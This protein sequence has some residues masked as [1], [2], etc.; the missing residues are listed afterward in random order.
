MARRIR[1]RD[2]EY[3]GH[4]NHGQ[5]GLRTSRSATPIEDNGEFKAAELIDVSEFEEALLIDKN[6]LDEHLEQQADLF[7]RVSKALTLA[8]SRRDAAKQAI[9]EAEA[10]VELGLHREKEKYTVSE[11]KAHVTVNPR[12]RNARRMFA[13]LNRQVM[14]LAGLKEAFAQRSYAMKELV[15]LY[16]GSYWGDDDAKAAKRFRNANA[17]HIRREMSEM[18]RQ[19]S[20]D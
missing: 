5:D 19:R 4:G 7:N 13:D 10:E 2:S 18:R 17:D 11:I 20:R 15:S 14:D 16:L 8:T 3:D 9:A 12:V 6:A 1:T